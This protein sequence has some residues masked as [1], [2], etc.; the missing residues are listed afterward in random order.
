MFVTKLTSWLTSIMEPSYKWQYD[1]FLKTQ[2]QPLLNHDRYD[3]IC[4]YFRTA[5]LKNS[6]KKSGILGLIDLLDSKKNE[7][8]DMAPLKPSEASLESLEN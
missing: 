8:F 5:C 4:D 1:E 7:I 2:T 3:Q 6:V